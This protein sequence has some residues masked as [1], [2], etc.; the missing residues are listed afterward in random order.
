MKVLSGGC[1]V[2]KSSEGEI[3]SK[4][5]SNWRTVICYA[6]GADKITQTVSEH[7][8]G[9]SPVLV[10]PVAEEALY[11]VRGE[12]SCTINGFD[13]DLSPGTGVYIPPAAEYGFEN[14]RTEPLEIVHACCPED[15]H[16]H[17]VDTPRA[18]ALGTAPSLLVREADR[19][20]IRAGKDREFRYLVHTDLGCRQIT[21]F[22]GRIPPSMAPFHHHDYEEGIFIL[23]GH[24][25]VHVEGE[26]C[27]FGPSD[28][29]YFPVGVRHCVENPGPSPIQLL[30]AFYPSGSP[31]A[32]YED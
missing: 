24:G 3:S 14:S 7:G 13:Y 21:Q 8:L 1:R 20:V 2:F 23:S 9:C 10:N 32:A 5:V 30:G 22:A 18:G 28:S 19:E 27:A 4:G 16:R 25:L 26:S 17:I 12:G 29:I 6:T 31:G 11:V 15:P